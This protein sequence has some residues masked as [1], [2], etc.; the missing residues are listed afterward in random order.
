M[1]RPEGL[2]FL[3]ARFRR[4]E[5]LDRETGS[6]QKRK[7]FDMYIRLTWDFTLKGR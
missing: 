3:E 1:W 7:E 4:R 6:R 2:P 5:D